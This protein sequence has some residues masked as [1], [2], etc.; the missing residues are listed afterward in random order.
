MT[1]PTSA[2]GLAQVA[3]RVIATLA[4]CVL[5]LAPAAAQ[6]Q[7]TKKSE[8]AVKNAEAVAAL[9]ADIDKNGVVILVRSA[10]LGLDQANKT[11]NYSVLRDLGSPA[12]QAK[13]AADLAAT[14][15]GHRN[16]NLDLAGILVL[17]PQLTL[18]PQIEPDGM[19]HMAG[20]FPSVPLQVNF[21]MLWEPVN[22]QWRIYGLS[23]NLSSGGPIAPD[24]PA[25]PQPE[26]SSE[27]PVSPSAMITF[28]SPEQPAET[29]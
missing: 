27:P 20:F 23:V 12:F 11:G 26:G 2:R 21:E 8:R 7:T 24:G 15:A 13:T 6:T 25:A 9:P 1:S 14:F 3:M 29:E 10:L 4:I 28:D 19:L 22:R 18:L 5:A 17:E 16:Q